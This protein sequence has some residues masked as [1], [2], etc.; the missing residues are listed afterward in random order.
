MCGVLAFEG[1][2]ATTLAELCSD[3]RDAGCV[4]TAIMHGGCIQVHRMTESE[5]GA[6]ETA[7]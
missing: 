4:M 2:Q 3:G 6:P 5:E 1:E 7:T